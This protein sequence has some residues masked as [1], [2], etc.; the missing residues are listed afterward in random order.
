MLVL[1]LLEP[2]VEPPGVELAP[3]LLEVELELVPPLVLPFIDPDWLVSVCELGLVPML[4]L[5]PS[6]PEPED[7]V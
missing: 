6:E 7:C 4:P 5:V 2:E 3:L 1:L